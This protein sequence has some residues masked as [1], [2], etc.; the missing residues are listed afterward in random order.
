MDNCV[1]DNTFSMLKKSMGM[2]PCPFPEIIL[3]PPDI[4]PLGKNFQ[5]VARKLVSGSVRTRAAGEKPATG[6]TVWTD[7]Y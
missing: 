3:K 2:I 6:R 5:R 4:S 7:S 1:Q